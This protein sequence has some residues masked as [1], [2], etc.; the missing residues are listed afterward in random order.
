[1]FSYF[2]G[3]LT[4]VSVRYLLLIQAPFWMF[5]IARV[6][7]SATNAVGPLRDA[8]TLEHTKKRKD[9]ESYGRQRLFA[10]LAWGM[11]SYLGGYLIGKRG[12]DGGESSEGEARPS[13]SPHSTALTDS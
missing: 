7:R 9:E 13:Y 10:S 1:M 11:G 3:L 2:L 6:L 5:I 8:I 12:G 4:L